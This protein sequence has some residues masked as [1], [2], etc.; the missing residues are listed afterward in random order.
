MIQCSGEA[1]YMNDTLTSKN[2]VYCE[3]VSA[4][5]VGANIEQIDATEALA[6]PGV[7]AFYSAKDIPG[8]NTFVEPSIGYEMEEIFCAAQVK[9]YDQPLGMIVATTSDIALQASTKV[10]VMYSQPSSVIYTSMPEVLNEKELLEL[11]R[12]HLIVESKVD[13]PVDVGTPELSGSGIFQIGAQYHYTM[14]PQ[15]TIAVPFEDGLQIWSATQWMD[16]TQCVIAKMLQLNVNSIQLKVRRLGGAY[17]CKITRGNIVACGAALAAYKLNRPARFVQRIESMMNVNGKRWGC[18]SDYEFNIM[19][20][21]K[22]TS[23]KNLFYQDAGLNLNENPIDG[24]STVCAKNCYQFTDK[25]LKLEGQAVITDAPSAAYC[26][27][28]GSVEG[29]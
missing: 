1:T 10:K 17:G 21:G 6:M 2:S 4:T 28:P 16:H 3:F 23:L 18:R 19:A 25:N 5:K 13:E 12:L 11:D 8:A 9:Y 27:A 20:N 7:L 14:E 24:H 15:T 22:I 26:R 29:E